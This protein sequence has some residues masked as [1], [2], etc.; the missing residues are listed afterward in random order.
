M[1]S[2]TRKTNGQNKATIKDVS[3]V[4][5]VSTATV[6]RVL[7]GFEEVSEETRQRVLEAAK[8]LNYQPNRNARNLRKNTTST[9]GVIISDIQNPFFG[10]VVRGIEKVTIKDDYT[11]IL[12]NSDEDPEREKKLITMLLEEGVAGIILVPTN[13]NMES[14]AA[15]FSYGTPFVVID[16]R[17]P[18]PDLDMVLVDGAAGAE[19][20]VDHMVSLGHRR[21]GYVGGMKH[22]SVMHERE[23]GYMAALRKHNLPFVQEYLRQGNNRL[24]GGYTAVCELISLPQPPSA[25]LI[26]NNMMTLGGLQ[27][28]HEDGLEIPGQISLIGFDDMDWAASLRPPLT[29]VAQP[30]YEMGE[31]AASIL[32]ERIHTPGHPHQ[33]V[34]LN[35]H[36]VVRASCKDMS[37]L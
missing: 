1:A 14:Y 4:A 18:I 20:A 35:T 9:I 16:R 8:T 19:M 30:A 7:A 34:V 5:G 22:L 12:G 17:L 24:D 33:T 11:L 21:I 27:A 10:S 25:I 15:L 2:R 29:C 36:L 23:L 13:A 37:E 31:T 6:S 28:I 3:Q 32:L 26:A